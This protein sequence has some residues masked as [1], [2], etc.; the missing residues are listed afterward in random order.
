LIG[1][2]R[3]QRDGFIEHDLDDPPTPG[4]FQTSPLPFLK[5]LFGLRRKGQSYFT[6]HLGK[7]LHSRVLTEKDFG[8]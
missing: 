5:E 6:T 3:V 4:R 1:D 7:I 2:I 8:L